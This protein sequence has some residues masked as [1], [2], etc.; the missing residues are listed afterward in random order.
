LMQ[1][2]IAQTTNYWIT[3]TD[4][5]NSTYSIQHPAAFL[6]QKAI[7]RRVRQQL[8]IDASDLPV[9]A[10]YINAVTATGVSVVSVSK[11]FNAISVT[12]SDPSKIEAIRNLSFVKKITA[13]V[14]VKKP[15]HKYDMETNSLQTPLE[16]TSQRSSNV[17][18]YGLSL[19]QATQIGVNCLHNNGYQGQGMT[20]GVFDVGF[21]KVDSLPAFDSIRVNGQI[22]GTHDFVAGGTSVYEDPAHGMNTL[23]CIA[24]NLPGRLVGTS[25]K[26]NFWLLRTED[27]ASESWQEEINWLAA[28]EF[29]DSVGVDVISSSLGYSIGMTDP[30]QNHTYSEMDGNTTIVTNAADFAASKGIFVTTSAGNSAGPPWYKITAPGDADSVLTS[31]AVD[32]LGVI[33]SFSS[34][35]PTF[36]GRIKPTVCARGVSAIVASVLGDV[37]GESGTSFSAPITAGAVTCLWQAHP[38][39]NIIQLLYAIEL[40]ASQ[41]FTPDSIQGFGIPNFCIADSLLNIM[42][43]GVAENNNNENVVSVYPN[44][45]NDQINIHFYAP[46]KQS[47]RME[48]VDVAGRIIFSKQ[49]TTNANNEL[50]I[51][52]ADTGVLS[53]GLYILRFTTSE[54]TYFKKIIKK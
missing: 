48:L 28:A 5:N 51:T 43:L 18:N 49:Q 27:E 29:A 9:N 3:F 41:Y 8:P 34:R 2:T 20:I 54:K 19:N 7:D 38:A 32:S 30:L 13:I 26:A 6:S 25:P 52:T 12:T 50:V 17:F 45:F 16:S 36:D 40:S 47:I 23:S 14:I 10:T 35:G 39:A 42:G 11:W 1:C 21:Y 15:D 24:G 46:V 31:G 22:L 4:K 33:A 37:V 53:K 44:P